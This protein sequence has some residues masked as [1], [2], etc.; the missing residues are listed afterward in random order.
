M[1]QFMACSG[2]LLARECRDKLIPV[3]ECKITVTERQWMRMSSGAARTVDIPELMRFCCSIESLETLIES[4][5]RLLEDARK[6]KGH[7]ES[8]NEARNDTN[9]AP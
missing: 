8:V 5:Q 1:K 6:L 7:L 4:M 3:V 2:E 9:P